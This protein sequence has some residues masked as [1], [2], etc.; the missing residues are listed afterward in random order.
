M[1][2]LRVRETVWGITDPTAIANK[3]LV[4]LEE[5]SIPWREA[6]LTCLAGRPCPL[7]SEPKFL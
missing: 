5:S 3:S 7:S 6:L 2:P 1:S 4:S